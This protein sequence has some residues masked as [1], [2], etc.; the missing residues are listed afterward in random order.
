[1]RIIETQ[2]DELVAVKRTDVDLNTQKGRE[3]AFA[4][5]ATASVDLSW[6]KD[7]IGEFF[8]PED[9]EKFG[10]KLDWA[11][12]EDNFIDIEENHYLVEIQCEN[13][14][15]QQNIFEELQQ[16]GLKCKIS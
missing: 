16:R 3:M 5:N 9:I 14:Q 7:N 13:E 8:T 4:D 1:M 10:V 6:N 15:Q 11:E 12:K 2:G